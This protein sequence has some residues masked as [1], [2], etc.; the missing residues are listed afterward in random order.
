MDNN[1]SIG[2]GVRP[3]SVEVP[4]TVEVLLANQT[5]IYFYGTEPLNF[6]GENEL[7]NQIFDL[8]NN[9]AGQQLIEVESLAQ[10]D[11]AIFTDVRNYSHS[12]NAL[13][14][15]V[16]QRYDDTEEEKEKSSQVN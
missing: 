14:M 8:I 7:S 3:L 10:I 4:D 15:P 16:D 1:H 6:I 5:F 13:M 11:P 2:N 9:L 12:D